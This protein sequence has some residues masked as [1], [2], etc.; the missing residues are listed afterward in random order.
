[1]LLLLLLELEFEA[2]GGFEV[3]KAGLTVA[4]VGFPRLVLACL[5]VLLLL[6]GG[7]VGVGAGGGGIT[8]A[9]AG[10]G[11][12]EGAAVARR[13]V[14]RVFGREGGFMVPQKGKERKERR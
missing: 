12:G 14:L 11:A 5:E 3:N 6:G 2:E 9:G 10:E 1:M 13:E 8:G 4:T 7:G